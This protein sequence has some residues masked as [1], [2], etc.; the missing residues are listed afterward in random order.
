M[1]T[2]LAILSQPPELEIED[3]FYNKA[4]V[5]E[6]NLKI[7]SFTQ[8]DQKGIKCGMVYPAEIEFTS[9]SKGLSIRVVKIDKDLGVPFE[10]LGNSIS[11]G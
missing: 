6:H 2:K 8:I 4:C 7:V 10:L 5:Y 9:S 11:A 1:Q 3:S